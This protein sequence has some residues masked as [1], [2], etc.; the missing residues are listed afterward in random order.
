AI[1]AGAALAGERA[2]R[3]RR[4]RR[5]GKRL[6]GAEA[7]TAS[8]PQATVPARAAAEVVATRVAPRPAAAPAG[9]DKPGESSLLTRIGRGLKS[10]VTR[11][12]RSQH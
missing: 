6:E 2:P 3:K 10:L 4:R 1:A 5:G 12:P 8:R 11:A 7:A 9:A